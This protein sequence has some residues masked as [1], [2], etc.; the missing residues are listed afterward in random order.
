MKRRAF[1]RLF[2][3][4]AAMWPLAAPAQQAGK[5]PTIGVLGT[6]TASNWL[7]WTAGFVQ[8]LREHGWIEGRSVA[9][10]YR[11]S[12][13]RPQRFSEI[14]TEFVRLNVD[15]IVTAGGAVLAA[16]QATSVIPIVFAIANDPV[17]SGFISSLARPGG[18]VTGLSTQGVDLAGK[19]Y[20]LLSEAVPGLRRLAILGNA[21][22]PDSVVE[23]GEVQAAARKLGVEVTQ[24]EIRRAEEIA[25]RLE[26]L[27]GRADALYVVVDELVGAN[28]IRIITLALECAAA[29]DLQYARI[30]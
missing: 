11:W 21:D 23:M 15:V 30:C 12:D 10:E 9:I 2:G 16:K 5:L 14:A 18:N 8:R 19:R 6:A 29:H 13:G 7:P 3:G 27:K 4:A 24:L 1:I 28:S 20:G 17:A 22:Y 25:S 26:E